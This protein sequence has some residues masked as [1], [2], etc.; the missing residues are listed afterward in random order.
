M[1]PLLIRIRRVTATGVLAAVTVAVSLAITLSGSEAVA[2]FGLG[3]VPARVGGAVLPPDLFW[4]P[5][6]LTPLS[7]T[8]VHSGPLHLLSNMVLLVFAGAQ[9]ERVIGPRLLLLVYAAGA[10]ASAFAQWLPDPGSES[11]MVGASGA[12]SALLGV[13]AIYYGRSRARAIG[14]IPADFVQAAWLIAA[15]TV[16]NF[17]VALLAADYGLMIAWVAHVG[18]FVAGVAMARPLLKWRRA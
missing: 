9:V 10:Y 11:P 4:L 14:P 1:Q 13:Y 16:V 15:W 17:M 18:G 8:L 6:W 12:A 5:A 3:F 7:T 2:G